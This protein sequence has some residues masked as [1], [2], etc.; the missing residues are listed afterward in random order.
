MTVMTVD[1]YNYCAILQ[2]GDWKRLL[3]K[4]ENVTW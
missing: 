3:T 2:T 1:A 4:F